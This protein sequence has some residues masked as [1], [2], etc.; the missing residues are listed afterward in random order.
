M[1]TNDG[2]LSLSQQ[3]Q[4]AAFWFLAPMLAALF[5]VA[6]WPLLRTIWFSLTDTLLSDLYGGEWIGFDNYLS[7]RT[8]ESG[9][10]I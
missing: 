1:A 8:L 4:R 5:C 7:I 10:V 2:G 6:A 9:R 3:R